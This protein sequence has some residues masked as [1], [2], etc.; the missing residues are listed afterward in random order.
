MSSLGSVARTELAGPGTT[1]AD[2]RLLPVVPALQPLL[3][4]R[5]LRRGTTVVVASSAAL[6]LA[7]VAGASA[8]G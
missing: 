3:P 1:R 8:A 7:L 2:E 6:A 5:G 4:G